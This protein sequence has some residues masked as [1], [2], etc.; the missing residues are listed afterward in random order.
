[1]KVYQYSV[2]RSGGTQIRQVLRC[3]FG[4]DLVKGSHDFMEVPEETPLVIVYRDFRD[5]T[6]SQWRIWHAKFKG[7]DKYDNAP[8]LTEL[9]GITSNTMKLA[10][11]TL[12][13]YK[14]YYKDKGNILWLRYEDFYNNYDY[15]FETLEKFF[16][17]KIS[18]EKRKEIV[19][20]TNIEKNRKR[21]SE[22]KIENLGRPFDSYN[23]ENLI[24]S[25]HISHIEP[26]QG[27]WKKIVPEMF[28]EFVEEP[29]KKDLRE[30]GYI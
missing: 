5:V 20:N 24:H 13:N 1:M 19:E 25:A 17:I 21:A 10:L 29:L 11:K 7:N 3:L 9:N 30:W 22:V 26:K 27:Y 23:S 16:D 12:N 8:S 28:W 4:K 18:E 14:E 6:I 2:P 15:L